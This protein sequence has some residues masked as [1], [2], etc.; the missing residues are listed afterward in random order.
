MKINL[1]LVSLSLLF[2]GCATRPPALP[3][4]H[5]NDLS[6]GAIDLDVNSNEKY[7]IKNSLGSILVKKAEKYSDVNGS[8]PF[9]VLT[10]TGGGSRGA[11]GTGLLVG[12]TK[13]GDI[14]KFDII[15]GI[16]TGAVMAPFIFLGDEELKKVEHFYT[17]TNTEEVFTNTWLNFFGDGY[18]MNAK[19]LKKLFEET[20]NK[21]FLDKVA[22]EYKNG[23]RL[24]IGT[25]N[26][27]TGQLTVW[28]MGAIASSDRSDKYQKFCDI[29]YA[30]TALPIYLPPQYMKVDVNG[31]DYYQMHVDGGIYSQVFMIG[32]LVNWNEVLDF[33]ESA[34]RNFDVTLYTV[35]NRKYRQRDVYKPVE[36]SPMAIIEAYVLTEMDLLFD[37]SVYRLYSSCKKK[38]F[39]FK[40]ASVPEKMQDIII[41]PTEFKPDEMIELFNVGYN[42][43]LNATP[44]KEDI[45]FDEYDNNQY[46][47]LR[48]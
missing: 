10:L 28:D 43:G 17:K 12:W 16:S 39:K 1:L 47:G 14:P 5:A 40:I 11:F 36:Q 29:V 13:K 32:L 33:K 6:W 18:I 8:V 19:P 45:S 38:G 21:D 46:K 4:S 30:S 25:T 20:F 3:A 41:T 9:D 37:R 44:W 24:Y 34:N 27:D 2:F 42:L 48:P 26:I 22:K 15:T 7:S 35:A 23:R 31:K